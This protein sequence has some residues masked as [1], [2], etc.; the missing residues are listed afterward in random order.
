MLLFQL[1]CIESRAGGYVVELNFITTSKIKLAHAAYLCRDYAVAIRKQRHYGKGYEEPRILDRE[2][3]LSQSMED[4]LARWVKNV[5]NPGEKLFFI[6]DTSVVIHA[7]SEEEREVPG[8]DVKFWMQEHDFAA[9][10]CLLKQ[11]GNDRRVTVRSDALL[12]LTKE[13]TEKVGQKTMR[14]SSQSHGYIVDHEFDFKANRVYP[15]LDNKT[16]NKW[17]VPDGCKVPISML[18]VVEADL[19]DFRAGAFTDMLSFLEREGAIKRKEVAQ[20]YA[21][22]RQVGLPVG[23]LLF[24]ICGPT[25]AGK[26]TLAEYLARNYGYYHVEASDFMYLSY[27]ER[28]GVGSEVNIGEFAK[29]IL[30]ENPAIVSEQILQHL[31]QLNS[32]PVVISGFRA[33]EETEHFTENY[34]GISGVE[35]ITLDAPF[36]IRLERYLRRDRIENASP[37]AFDLD[38]KVQ[39]E[40]GLVRLMEQFD[41]CL[42]IND[43]SF[44]VLYERFKKKY[45]EKLIGMKNS[46]E[47]RIADTHSTGLEDAILMTLYDRNDLY[48]T[49]AEVAGL[50]HEVFGI[51]KSKNNV[52]RYFNQNFHPFFEI[53]R[54][55]GVN[56]YRLSQTGKAHALWFARKH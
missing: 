10:D 2:V 52:S 18:P 34:V 27:Y 16:F 5:S 28:F 30:H 11:R 49:T 33:P 55:N 48:Y 19:Y 7:L 35:V 6:E 24:V 14:F 23:P 12:S 43:A 40:M 17:F 20:A 36:D 25:C 13:M 29:E 56:K 47:V 38:S 53:Q 15:W 22:G 51:E 32:S 44:D 4:A 54:D 1:S 9:V 31:K 8:V 50:I 42:I 39:N 37:Q 3:L 41:G 45:E 21:A 26:T 46:E